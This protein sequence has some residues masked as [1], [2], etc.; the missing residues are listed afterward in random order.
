[1]SELEQQRNRRGKESL[2]GIGEELDGLFTSTIENEEEDE[3]AL[4]KVE[5]EFSTLLEWPFFIKLIIAMYPRK[6]YYRT[7]LHPLSRV[8]VDLIG[9]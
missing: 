5:E 8:A 9:D 2:D 6:E 1:M 7:S 3:E 4:K